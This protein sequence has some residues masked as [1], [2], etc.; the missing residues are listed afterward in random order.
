MCAD[1]ALAIVG[2]LALGTLGA[3]AA[4]AAIAAILAHEDVLGSL[5]T[6][7]RSPDG[8]N[9]HLAVPDPVVPR[10]GRVYASHA[11]LSIH[12]HGRQLWAER[13][14]HLIPSGGVAP[15]AGAGGAPRAVAAR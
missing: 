13:S 6:N 12:G 7:D 5:S 8:V 1:Y 4:I 11:P 14:T 15:M 9:R 2:G 3:L 10:E